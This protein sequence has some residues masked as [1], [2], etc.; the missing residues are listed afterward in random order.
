MTKRSSG[1]LL[2]ITSL[3]SNYGIGDFGP[4]ACRFADFLQA[5]GQRLWQVLPLNPTNPAHGNSP[6][7]SS[8][9]FAGSE[10]L[11]SPELMVNDGFLERGDLNPLPGFS[12]DHVDY[13]TV[14]DYKY[15]IIDTAWKK[16]SDKHPEWESYKSF[17][18]EHESWLDDYTL[19]I[20]LKEKFDGN[21]WNHWPPPFRDRVTQAMDEAREE[22]SSRIERVRFGQFLFYYQLD[23]L[24][25]YANERDIQIFGDIPIYVNYDSVDTWAHT[26]LFK[27]NGQKRSTVVAGVPP[28]YFSKTGQ[29]WGNP[30]YDWDTMKENRY[31][32]WIHR[33]EH[34]FKLYDIVRIDH[35]RG[36]VA[37]WQVPAGEKTAINGKWV[38]APVDDF[39]TTLGDHFGELPIVAEDLGMITDD[40]R[41]VMKRYGFPGMK[42]L[43]FAFGEDN[44]DHPYLPENFSENSVV[45]TGTHDNNTV[46]GW[47]NNEADEETRKRFFKYLGKK[48]P[49]ED[50][51]GAM[52]R[53]AMKSKANYAVIPIQ[54]HL[55]LP[56]YARMNTP[57][58]TGNGNWEWRLHPDQINTDIAEKIAKLTSESDR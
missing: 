29:L 14:R 34:T 46:L 58:T 1:I 50:V 24:K 35:F 42:I 12:I 30:V 53:M 3:P 51:P 31:R 40:V 57:A 28:D 55:A 4:Q 9:A 56:E 18:A 48:V 20:A 54:D 6:Y 33:L 22:L 39:L 21:V 41:E 25:K 15:K 19:F 52:I 23:A 8:S 37:Y 32:W 7:S 27:L 17:C 44:P 38:K 11:I 43:M 2:H 26:D 36:L 10:L 49:A 16:F 45:Y 5:A 47:F 13:Q